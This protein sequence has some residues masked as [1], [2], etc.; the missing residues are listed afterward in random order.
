MDMNEEADLGLE[1]ELREIAALLD[2]VPDG[3]LG[4]A[5]RAFTLRTLD[6]ELAAL[7]F[8]SWEEEPS[9]SVR[10]GAGPR[11]LTY[12]VGGVAVELEVFAARLVGRVTP[13]GPARIAVQRREEELL[14][15]SD[16]LGRFTAEGL[17]R[18]PLRLRVTLDSGPTVVTSWTRI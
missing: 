4:D 3:L 8:D 5:M 1:N 15:R 9:I 16:P 18:G 7:T 11:L 6:A 12:E 10:G 17:A 14:V 2:P 13:E